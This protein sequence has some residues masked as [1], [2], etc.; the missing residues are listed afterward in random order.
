[1]TTFSIENHILHFDD[2]LIVVNKPSG[3]R[4]IPDGYDPSLPNVRDLL[5]A[6]YHKIWVVHRLDKDTSGILLFARDAA[7]HRGLSLQ[8]EN[9][10]TQKQYQLIVIGNPD[11]NAT[12]INLPLRVNG[13]RKHRTV[14]DFTK[15]KAAETEFNIK[16][17]FPHHSLLTAAPHSGYTH[18]IRAHISAGG[19]PILGDSLYWKAAAHLSKSN[20]PTSRTSSPSLINRVALHAAKI[21]IYDIYTKEN[22][23]FVATPPADFLNCID[24]IRFL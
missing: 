4:V 6:L 20:V 7:T 23:T 17:C 9:R 21:T 13:D 8:F 2:H 24:K 19:F 1:M 22:V 16:E 14:V 12:S 11:W 15:G 3:L 5:N 18:Q 10:S